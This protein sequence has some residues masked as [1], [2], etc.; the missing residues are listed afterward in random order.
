MKRFILIIFFGLSAFLAKAQLNSIELRGGVNYNSLIGKEETPAFGFVPDV[1]LVANFKLNEKLGIQTGINRFSRYYYNEL[2]NFSINQLT[3]KK[4]INNSMEL[5][6]LLKLP[7][8]KDN[9][10]VFVFG[11][12]LG[13][14]YRWTYYEEN[15]TNGILEHV[16]DD[17]HW[18]GDPNFITLSIT[19]GLSSVLARYKNID[20]KIYLLSNYSL[21]TEALPSYLSLIINLGVSYQI[22]KS[23][24]E[25]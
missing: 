19:G 3:T 2:T 5:T 8:I 25:N 11:P 7:L 15:Y 23:K 17:Q 13:M 10:L 12:M 6:M 4:V 21:K 22:N 16:I 20:F 24:S 1:S 18:R 9:R 14:T